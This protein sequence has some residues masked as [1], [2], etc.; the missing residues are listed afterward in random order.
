MIKLDVKSIF[1]VKKGSLFQ[2]DWIVNDIDINK[3]Y[4]LNNNPLYKRILKLRK[5]LK[6]KIGT[7]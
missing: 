3:I 1:K 6:N 7:K 4:Y 2:G 5:Q